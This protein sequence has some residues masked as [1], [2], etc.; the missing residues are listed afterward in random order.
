M[1][2]L[3]VPLGVR[4]SQKTAALEMVNNPHPEGNFLCHGHLSPN[5]LGSPAKACPEAA[6]LCVKWESKLF[7]LS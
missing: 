6:R 7:L 1:L 3:V 4:S 5:K 2:G